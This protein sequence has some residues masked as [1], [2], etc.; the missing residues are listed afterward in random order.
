M[1]AGQPGHAHDR[2][3]PL[4]R[5]LD[6]VP[7]LGQPRLRRQG[8]DLR[9]GYDYPAKLVFLCGVAGCNSN[10][11]ATQNLLAFVACSST[12]TVGFTIQNSSVFQGAIYVVNDYT[13]Q[14][15]ANV[16]GPI[17]ARQISLQNSSTNHYVPL[18]TLLGGMPQSSQEAVSIVNQPGSWG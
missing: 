9:R 11:Q 1:D 18:G 8:H 4:L 6:H 5:R 17:I 7:E 12:D 14:N 16:W 15:S 2:R 10:W 13:E 3:H